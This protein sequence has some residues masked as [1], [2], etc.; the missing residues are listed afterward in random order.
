MIH[1]P[2]TSRLVSYLGRPVGQP[3]PQPKLCLYRDILPSSLASIPSYFPFPRFLPPTN[4]N[5]FSIQRLSITPPALI[6]PTQ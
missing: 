4:T 3:T 5:L 1:G 2:E 6:N